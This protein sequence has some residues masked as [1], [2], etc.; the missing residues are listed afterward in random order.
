MRTRRLRALLM[1]LTAGVLL[2]SPL[3]TAAQPERYEESHPEA[4]GAAHAFADL[5][6]RTGAGAKEVGLPGWFSGPTA[7]LLRLFLSINA[8]FI[9]LSLIHI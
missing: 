3:A 4:A 1:L 6:A 2:L 8:I 7:F 5:D 9:N